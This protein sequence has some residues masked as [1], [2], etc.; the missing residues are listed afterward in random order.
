LYCVVC[1]YFQGNVALEKSKQKKTFA[2]IPDLGWEDAVRLAEVS[3][4]TFGN[5]LKD[6]TEN[7]SKWK[8]VYS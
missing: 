7:E 3:P 5:L 1:D 2:W 4:D 6:I 8:Q